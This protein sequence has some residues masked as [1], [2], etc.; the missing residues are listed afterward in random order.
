MKTLPDPL[1]GNLWLVV[2][3]TSLTDIIMELA[4]RLALRG[5]LR[6]VDG[7]N[8]FNAYRCSRAL[9]KLL[10]SPQD[11]QDPR[12]ETL[13]GALARIYVSRAFTCYQ[14]LTLLEELPGSPSPILALD[15]LTTFYDEDVPTT[16]SQRLLEASVQQLLRLSR[17]APVVVTAR[18]IRSKDATDDRS[19]L[20]ESLQSAA[21]RVWSWEPVIPLDPQMRLEI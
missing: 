2:A 17:L 13:A 21:H 19:A 6:V 14:M 5:E 12:P 20:L 3:P 11:P 4:A 8:R 10:L 18:G 1:P 16:E 15:L 7:G 9:A